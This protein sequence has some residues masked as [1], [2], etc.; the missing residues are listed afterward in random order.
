VEH[1]V[2]LDIEKT[3]LL[4]PF[5]HL[6]TGAMAEKLHMNPSILM[7]LFLEKE[8]RNSSVLLSGLAIPHIVVEGEH[9]FDILLARSKEG[10]VFDN[11][12]P[13][14]HAVFL[15]AGSRDER[16]FHLQAL[17]AVAQIVQDPRF[18]DKWLKARSKEALRDIVLLG[19]RRRDR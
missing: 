6:A 15:L 14:V 13:P 16:N 11:N 12:K 9:I 17:A 5:F 8:R 10:I 4:E 18:E 19:E 7:S 2:V 3:M 1:C